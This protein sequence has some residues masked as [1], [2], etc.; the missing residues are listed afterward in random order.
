MLDFVR[1]NRRLMLLLLLVLVFPSF[2]FFGVESYSRFMDGSH[3]VA[4]VDGR[5]ITV[6]EVDNVVRD[7]SERMRQMLGNNYDP[8]MFEGAA[9]RQSVLDQLIQQRVVADATEKKHLTVSDTQVRD[10]IQAIPAIAQLRGP[11]G[12]FDEKAYVQL[13]AQQGMTPEQLDSRMRFELATQQLG[14]AVGTTSF[15]PKSLLDRLIAIRDQ[16]RD[17]QPLTIKSAD[18]TSKVKPDEAA[19][20]AYYESHL[21]AYTTPEEAKVEYVVLSGEA[22]AASQAVTPE[23][24]KSYYDS[25]IQRFRTEEQRRASHILIAAPKDGKDAD[26]KAAK[27]KAEKLLAE[28]KKH[29]ET[30]ADVAKKNSQDPGSAEKGG[31]LGFMGHGALVKPFEDAMYALKDGQISDLVETDYGYH[32]IKLTGIKP[33]ETQPLDA[34]RPELEAELKKQ[35]ASKKYAEQADAFGNT[36]Y[37][38]SDSLKPAADKFKLTIQTADNVTRQPNP[39]LGKDSPLN[40]EKLLK[41]LFSDDVLKNKRNTEA[42]Q[43]G[44]TTLVAARVVDYRPAAAR[45]FEDVEAQVRQAYIAQQAAELARKD[46]EARLEAL[47]KGG[48]ADGFGATIVVSRAKADGLPPK[49]VDAIMR[50]DATKLPSVVGVDLGAEGYAIYRVTKVSTPPAANPGQRDADAQQLSQLAGQTELAAYYDALKA[51][52]K[53]K[54]LR[55]AKAEESQPAN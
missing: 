48:N 34:V 19:L 32:I 4:K 13:L 25:N 49:A 45:K 33:A 14:A 18:F 10:A 29:P 36:V 6:Q 47:K 37:E 44:P 27:E 54:I 31:D 35:L 39:A 22:L 28:V 2:V 17:V 51:K 1:N 50:A 30:F 52:A 16:Q 24:L 3:D 43:V 7:Q 11:D 46:G 5:T 38:Q 21:S 20:K 8:R 15:V 55:P 26:R 23:E 42:V 41:A 12:T 40:N 53:V 9:A